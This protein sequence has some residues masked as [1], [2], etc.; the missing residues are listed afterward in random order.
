M[1]TYAFPASFHTTV[2]FMTHTTTILVTLI[3]YKIVMIL[4]GLFAGGKTKDETDFFLGGRTLGPWIASLSASASSSSA[5]T[6]LGVS[7]AAYAWGL[8]ALWIF[9]GCLGGFFLNWYLVASRLREVGHRDDALTVTDILAG[10]KGSP[11]RNTLAITASAI[12]LFS[13]LFYVASQ[14]QGSGKT[15]EAAF[16]L[17]KNNAILLGSAIIIFY[18]LIGG[19]WAVS[20]TDALQGTLMALTAL[21]LPVG[22]LFAV[23]GPLQLWHAVN[24]IEGFN[25][26]ARN[27]PWAAGLGFVFGLLG[28]GLGYPGQPHVVNRYMAMRDETAVITGRRIA[29]VWALIVYTGMLV[30]GLCGR[31]LFPELADKELV[32]LVA[33]QDLFHPLLGGIMIAA[34]LSA[35]MSTADSQLLVAASCVT[36]DLPGSENRKTL[37]VSRVAVLLL[38]AGAV[39]VAI[40]GT[41]E[42]FSK[43]LFAW[44]AMGSAFGPLLLVIL[45]R[46]RVAAPYAL[47]AMILGFVLS[48][49]A[50]SF[51]ASKGT[52]VERI[53]PFVV[54]LAVAWLGAR[55]SAQSPRA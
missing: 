55:K 3:V 15:F 8:S 42:I 5:W 48:V 51:P 45:Y 7:G 41:N 1:V 43:V 35:T 38:S 23:G 32:F 29:L 53:L 47:A 25:S 18:T 40:Y 49:T 28:I 52:A 22:A 9:P 27:L 36:H 31:V 6:L 54:A 10:P 16:G 33:A 14:F 34:V 44:S 12:I 21:L 30:L 46:G 13:L 39:L 2:V 17:S 11:L 19:F 4:I 50:Y 37:V 26:V 24:E 20:L